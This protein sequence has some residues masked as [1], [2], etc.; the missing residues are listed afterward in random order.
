[1]P[2]GSYEHVLVALDDSLLLCLR[3]AMLM[4][5]QDPM[6]SW[7]QNPPYPEK[8]TSFGL[9]SIF[10]L[11][12]FDIKF[13]EYNHMMKGKCRNFQKHG[14]LPNNKLP[15]TPFSMIQVY[16]R[17]KVKIS[18]IAHYAA[19][20]INSKNAGNAESPSGHLLNKATTPLSRTKT[21]LCSLWNFACLP[22]RLPTL[23]YVT[24]IVSHTSV[25]CDTF[26][27]N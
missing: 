2:T 18:V 26:D 27:N 23:L 13:N 8:L 22:V 15:L 21:G 16:G 9:N 25:G 10:N 4:V 6:A 1:M 19:D 3:F 20:I 24:K 7:S 5:L 11:C 12:Y 17:S 14:S